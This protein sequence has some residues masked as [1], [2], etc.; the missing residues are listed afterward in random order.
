MSIPSTTEGAT[1]HAHS[2]WNVLQWKSAQSMASCRS[3]EKPLAFPHLPQ[4]QLPPNKGGS[5]LLYHGGSLLRC[6]NEGAT[7]VATYPA[8]HTKFQST[9]PRGGRL[10]FFKSAQRLRNPGRLRELPRCGLSCPHA[11]QRFPKIRRIHKEIRPREP[12]RVF[13]SALGSRY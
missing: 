11:G 13:L 5:F 3:V 10:T 4:A 7:N 1:Q 2:R 6:Q 12:P 8:E 9:P